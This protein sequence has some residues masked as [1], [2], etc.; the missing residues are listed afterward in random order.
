ME[1]DIF[2]CLIGFFWGINTKYMFIEYSST[3]RMTFVHIAKF[4]WLPE[5][6][7][8]KFSRKNDKQSVSQKPC[9]GWS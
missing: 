4:D 1:I 7:K 3:I 8:G 6:E 5:Q 9:G 2:I